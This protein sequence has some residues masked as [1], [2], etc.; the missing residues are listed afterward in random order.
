MSSDA[1]GRI[2]AR[3]R[4]LPVTVN[5]ES[6]VIS[7]LLP[8]SDEPMV[9]VESSSQLKMAPAKNAASRILMLPLVM[10]N[11]G[12]HTSAKAERLYK[13]ERFKEFEI[14]RGTVFGIERQKRFFG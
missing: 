12:F 2:V 3:R 10:M 13:S 14:F 8:V 6:T 4:V 5:A 9:E 7:T 1:F 11:M